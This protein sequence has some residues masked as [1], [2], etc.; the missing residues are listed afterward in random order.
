MQRRSGPSRRGLIQA[1]AAG[2]VAAAPSA[3]AQPTTVEGEYRVPGTVVLRFVSKVN[4]VDYS[5]Y[6]RMPREDAPSAK[7]YPVICTLD[8]D[9]QFAICGNHLEHLSDRMNQAPKAILVSIAYKGVYPS[10]D[11]YHR[12]RTRD[13][14]PVF[15]PDDGYGPEFQK[16]SGG[17]PAFLRVIAEEVMPLINARYATDPADWTL[18]G[19]SYGGLFAGWTFQ[20]RPGLFRRY[21]IVSPSV[22]YADK[23]LVKR[24]QSKAYKAPTRAQSLYFCVGSWEEQPPHPM[25]SQ[26][27]EL[28]GLIRKRGDPHVTV[29]HRVFEDETHASI[30]PAGFSTGVRHLFGS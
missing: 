4:G 30:F 20:E 6:V 12:E 2:G 1:I 7:R 27:E 10:V 8:A 21:L 9:Y 5:L 14:T 17:G 19:H 22:W 29:E 15:W 28:A 24:E 26:M 13:Y 25:A 11:G 3:H 18:V 23:L 16:I